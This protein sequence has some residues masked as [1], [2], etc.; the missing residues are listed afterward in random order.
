MATPLQ[1]LVFIVNTQRYALRLE[2]VERIVR[3]VEVTSLPEASPGLLGVVNIQGQIVPVVN[4]R[5]RFGLPT[6]DV[7][8]DDRLIIVDSADRTIA[9]L[10]DAVVGVMAGQEDDVV[11]SSRIDPGLGYSDG[12]IK[13]GE[14]M[15]LI[16]NLGNI[17]ERAFPEEQQP[18][19]EI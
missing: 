15:V 18:P 2:S 13:L 17:V 4:F 10:V 19:A 1:L 14:D 6:R 11:P 3:A 9:L 8:L 12:M 16:P 7:D 5:K